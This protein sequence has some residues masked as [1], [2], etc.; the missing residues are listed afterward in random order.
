MKMV[1]NACVLQHTALVLDR[2][3]LHRR[4]EGVLAA[5]EK[6]LAVIKA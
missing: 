3:K 5:M 6:A 1:K 4:R 2:R